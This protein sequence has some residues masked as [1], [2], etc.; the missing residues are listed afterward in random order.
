MSKLHR[1]N[2]GYVGCSY[3]DTQ[4]PYYSYNK[5]A[6]PLAESD[7]T[8]VRDEVTFT[9][10]VAGGKFVIDG[11]SQA[12]VS[13]LEGNVYT[14]DQSDSSNGSHPLKFSYTADGTHGGGLE[15]T[16]GVTTNGTPGQSG[17][18]T[19]IV[20]PFGLH[21][22]KYYCGNHSGMGGSANVVENT[23]AFTV[24]RPILKTTDALG[25]SISG[26]DAVQLV[27][28]P[29]SSTDNPFGTG[30][31]FSVD[32]D[33]NDALRIQGGSIG[34]GDWTIEYWIKGSDFSG[35]QRH[36]SARESTYTSESTNLRSLNGSW[37]FYAGDDPG[38][39]SYAGTSITT[40]TWVHAAVCRNGTTIEYFA[41]GSRIATDSIGA[42]VTT[43]LTE[44]DVAH[45]Y[46][47]EYF[48]GKISNV[49]VSNTAR[50]SGSSYTIPT[51]TFSSDA[52][53]LLLA[54]YTSDI[55][56]VAGTWSSGAWVGTEFTSED[57]YAANLVLAIPMNGAD[58][59]TTFTDVSATLRGSGSAK[60]VTSYGVVTETDNSIF[61]GSSG[62]FAGSNDYLAVSNSSDFDFQSE[63]FT[64]E[65]WIYQT[66]QNTQYY[67]ISAKYTSSSHS[68]WWAVYGNYQTCY[69]YPGVVLSN[70]A[71]TIPINTWTHVAV[72]CKDGVAKLFQNGE[73]ID[74]KQFSGPMTTTTWQVTFGEDSDGNYDFKGYMSDARIYKG[75]AKYT[76]PFPSGRYGMD[77]VN[78]A[79]NSSNRSF[80]LN[81][82]PDLVWIKAKADGFHHQL[83]D[84]VRGVNLRLR[85]SHGGTEALAA[86]S[87][88]SFNSNGFSLG[89]DNNGDVNGGT[90]GTSYVAWTWRAGGAPTTDNVAGAGNVPTAGSVKVDGANMT[91]ALAGTIPAT[92]LTAST[93]FGFSVVGYT[94][95][96]TAGSTIAHG[97]NGSVPQLIIVKSRDSQANNSDWTV[98]HTAISPTQTLY[99]NDNG[100]K[101]TSGSWNDTAPGTSV[102]TV[103]SSEVV[104]TL[105][106]RYVAY[107]WS[108]V[109]NYSKF[110]S[111]SHDGSSGQT[112]DFGFKPRWWLVKEHDG[113]T[114]WYIF[115]AT[116]DNFD[117]PLFA[118]KQ[119]SGSSGW[120]FTFSGTS[121]TWVGGSS[122]Q[123]ITSTPHLP[124][125]QRVKNLK[126]T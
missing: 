22:L 37:Q 55:S 86:N 99:L 113:S 91:T 61:Y 112:L 39:Q 27:G 57:P 14:F 105:N 89:T 76:T 17:A 63:D 103:G 23:K 97:L 93:K 118:E 48:T 116:R 107:C 71:K 45:G 35:I 29:V 54:A 52:N 106:K 109:S 46:G 74:T 38:Y 43:T 68:W 94:G 83:F 117:D 40:D 88:I 4:D 47:S 111:F 85:S 19:K 6:L 121:V 102:F 126:V 122:L 82:R 100:G 20:V 8:V 15:Y 67:Q 1:D 28:D 79:G 25:A 33:G 84:S 2:A 101:S 42:S 41:D 90:G 92:R 108:E 21:D 7:K 66:E 18:Y 5:L 119:N 124:N 114:N 60:S 58:S 56:A 36:V 120:G 12:T 69:L 31:G 104:N 75:V 3:E 64:M 24:G 123:A 73:V 49:R 81:F 59:G 11:T 10:T 70:S 77:I 72:S 13:L 115:D 16:L 87:L 98:H 62:F 9:V 110:G 65:S 30:N 26:G 34:T 78:Y 125:L 80:T 53:T 96:G 44:V 32:F 51:A 50:Y 95:N